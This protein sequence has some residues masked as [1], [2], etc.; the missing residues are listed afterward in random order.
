[1]KLKIFDACQEIMKM[2]KLQLIAQKEQFDWRYLRQALEELQDYIDD[3]KGTIRGWEDAEM[4][5]ED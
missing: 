2:D 5:R 3:L 1:M 4:E